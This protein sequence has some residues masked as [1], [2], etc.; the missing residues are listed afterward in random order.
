PPSTIA[1]IA[2]RMACARPILPSAATL[3]TASVMSGTVASE[4]TD[5]CDTRS[6][7]ARVEEGARQPRQ[8]RGAFGTSRR[9]VAR[10]QDHPIGIEPEGGNLRG[11]KV[12]V[13]LLARTRRRR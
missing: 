2:W 13:V 7:S 12:S 6:A 9:R 5:Q 10:R 3:P 4:Y 8:C 11:R 1:S